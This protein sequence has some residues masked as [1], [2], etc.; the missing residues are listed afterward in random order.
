MARLMRTS[1]ALGRHPLVRGD[2]PTR[3]TAVLAAATVAVVLLSGS[4]SFAETPDPKYRTF[5][6]DTPG[7]HSAVALLSGCDGFAPPMAP[8]V[9][10]R[11][12]EHLRALGHLVIFVAYLGRR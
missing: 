6:P 10:E 7:P 1:G 4:P 8:T 2:M 12:A 11:R 3:R 5:R 9:Y